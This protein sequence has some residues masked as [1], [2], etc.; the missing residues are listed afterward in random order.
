MKKELEITKYRTLYK[1]NTM[2]CLNC[3]IIY[4]INYVYGF[5]DFIIFHIHLF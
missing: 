5:N 1:S 2:S 3:M 4:H